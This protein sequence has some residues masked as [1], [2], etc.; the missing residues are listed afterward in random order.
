MPFF[1]LNL[2]FNPQRHRS[3]QCCGVLIGFQVLR[4]QS[5]LIGDLLRE[6]RVVIRMLVLDPAYYAG[7]NGSGA[8]ILH[9]SNQWGFLQIYDK[10]CISDA[11]Y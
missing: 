2:G 9:D 1:D 7:L 11:L 10:S 8:S 5:D 4:S 3:V 6:P